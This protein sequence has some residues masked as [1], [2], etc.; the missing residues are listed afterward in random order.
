MTPI[1][2]CHTHTRYSDGADSVE[3]NVAAAAAAGC[4]VM[5][6]TDHLTLPASMDP[7]GAVGTPERDLARRAADVAEAAARHP[8][9]EVVY[10]F[11]CDW[12]EGCEED[13][14]R[15]SAGAVVRLGSV[16]WVS[17]AW[18]DDPDDRS[19]WE[20]LGPDEVWGRYVDAWCEACA[21]P[22][23]FDV[24]AHPDLAARF[25]NEGYPATRDL[26]PLY[27]RMAECAHDTRRRVE[28]STAGLRKTVGGYYPA[29]ELLRAFARAEVPIA[30][31]SDAHRSVDVAWGI[32]D[33]YAYA[34]ASGYRAI[35]VPH[36]D[37]SWERVPLE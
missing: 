4:A 9:V 28:V 26:R 36:A 10:G 34:A 16:H 1:V 6:A 31:G 18:I 8:E 19:I 17:G 15:W 12:Y 22:L 30:V 14:E 7:T 23:N 21:S 33:A 2:D 29:P 32:R 5:V 11:E 27:A 20:K 24:M 25:R 3:D 13:T 37:G 35:E